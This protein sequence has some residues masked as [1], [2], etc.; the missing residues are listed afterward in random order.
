MSPSPGTSTRAPARYGFLATRRWV[1]LVLFMLLVSAVCVRLGMWQYDRHAERSAEVAQVDAA[2][3]ADPVPAEQLLDADAEVTPDLEW[4]PVELTGRYLDGATVL[5]RNRSV[6]GT[7]AVR[8]VT[9]F[10]AEVD[11]RS[12]VVPVDRGWL[13]AEAGL[14]ADPDVPEAPSGTRSVMARLRGPEQPV[15]RSAPTGQVYSMDTAQVLD[16][17]ADV[18]DVSAAAGSPQLSGYAQLAGQDPDATP[19][20][21]PEP[22]VGLGPHLSYAVQWWL[23]AVG[24]LVG[25]VVLVRREAHDLD[26]A[27]DGGVGPD[28]PAH[29]TTEP[30]AATEPDSG[31]VPAPGSDGSDGSDG[32][33]RRH[34]RRRPSAEE[35]EDAI[36]DAQ[37][38]RR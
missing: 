2:Y 11:G 37:L 34:R 18:A 17:A 21:Y 20:P 16:A 28:G 15:G 36:V 27:P 24:A 30:D 13:P 6:S 31:A 3:D 22:D 38:R 26:A 25:L 10:L 19:A 35:E 9:P 14:V 33:G 12:L 5:L 23:F 4:L 7:P 32:R 1:S 29:A 8:V